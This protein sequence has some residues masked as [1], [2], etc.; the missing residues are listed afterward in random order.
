M[1]QEAWANREG[2]SSALETVNEKIGGCA[3]E[4]LVW[5]GS[6]TH[7]GIE[8]IKN[9]QK[10]IKVLNWAPP[11]QQN[12]S[13]FLQASKELDEWLR[14]QEIYWAQR[15]RVSWIKH[16]DK[17]SNFFHLKASQ[18]RQRNLIQGIMDP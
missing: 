3:S 5:G 6:K 18:H 8:E 17:N 13:D 10:R 2:C 4:L 7:P 15:S 14:K 9:L 1:I 11:T 12:R 16:G